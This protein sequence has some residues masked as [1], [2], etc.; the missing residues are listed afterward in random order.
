[1]NNILFYTDTPFTGGA[2]K[3]IQLLAENL[4]KDGYNV[5]VVCSNSKRLDEWCAAMKKNGVETLR[6]KVSHKHDP[7]HYFQL[8]KILKNLTPDLLHLH[9]WNPGACRYAFWAGAQ[10]GVKIITTEHDPF[11]LK[12]LKK[13]IK[14]GAMRKTVHTITVSEANYQQMLRWYPEQ[15]NL[16]SVIHNGIDL[17]AFEK[18][19]LHFTTQEKHKIRSQLFGAENTDTIILTVAALHPR[20]GLQYLIRGMKEVIENKNDVKLVI[21]GEGPEEEDLKK[22]IKKLKLENHIRLV[23]KQES[24][25]KI[26]KSSDLFVLPSVKEAFGLVLL[27][28]MAAQLPIVA[29]NVGGIPEIVEDR[30]SGFLVEPGSAEALAKTII[31]LLKNKPLREKI[32]F[33]GHH[34]VKRFGIESMVEKTKKIYERIAK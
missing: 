22:L 32:A 31:M 18:E 21:V 28:A 16:M 3:H 33:L 11:P 10:K 23:G 12:G 26:L 6:L 25:P 20:K 30:K 5:R 15:K 2:E 13:K 8:K 14:T 19:L 9:L 4:I 27:E 17:E 29:T 1:M 7:R 34:Q 24:I